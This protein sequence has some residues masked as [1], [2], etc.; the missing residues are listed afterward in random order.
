MG[1]FAQPCYVL[2]ENAIETVVTI[3]M[4]QDLLFGASSQGEPKHFTTATV[5]I[6]ILCLWAAHCALV[7]CD[8]MSD[9][10]STI[11]TYMYKR[12]T[13]THRVKPGV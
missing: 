8:W 2:P 12:H 13:L 10:S 3:I 6:A 7:I 11:H 4:L 5:Y 1:N 9:C